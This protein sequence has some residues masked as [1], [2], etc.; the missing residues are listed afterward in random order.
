[1]DIIVKKRSLAERGAGKIK[2][3]CSAWM[4]E[5]YLNW[6]E[7]CPTGKA[8]VSFEVNATSGGVG[9]IQKSFRITEMA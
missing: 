4:E 1:M 2:D 8:V 9:M 6:L 7:S 3:S 5:K